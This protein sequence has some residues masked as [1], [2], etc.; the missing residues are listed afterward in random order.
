[1]QSAPMT[2]IEE[3][4]GKA[5][6][7]EEVARRVVLHFAEVFARAPLP[8]LPVEIESLTDV[9]ATAVARDGGAS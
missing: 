6:S 2:S 9:A 8:L 1:M 3:L 4:T 5:Q 7:L